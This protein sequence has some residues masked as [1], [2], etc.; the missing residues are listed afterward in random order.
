MSPAS[1]YQAQMTLWRYPDVTPEMIIMAK[2]RGGLTVLAVQNLQARDERY[3]VPDP[4][5]P[6]LFL[7]IHPTGA[8]SWCFRYRFCGK[9]RKLTIGTAY[10]DKGI[11]VVK[12]GDAR[13]IADE[14]RVSVARQIDP[15]A[16]KKEARAKAAK[17]A[18]SA[19]TTLRAVSEAYL[20]AR[21]HL[22]TA[23]HRRKAF[24]RL[25][26]PK[27]GD[28]QIESIR[29]SEIAELMKEIAKTRGVVMADYCLAAMRAVFNS[30]AA[31]SDD[32]T[33]PIRRG[34][35]M[36]STKARAR[37]RTLSRIELAALWRACDRAGIFG[38]YVRFT[39][40]TATRRNEASHLRRTE[41]TGTDWTIPAA[42]Y[43]TKVDH[44]V[45]LSPA[46]VEVLASVPKIGRSG[47]VFTTDGDRPISGFG[48]R[49]EALDKL[50]L[51]E[52]RKLTGDDS[53]ELQRWTLHD[54]R[55]SARSLLSEAKVPADIGER[56]LGHVV[57]GVR[58]IYDRYE[59]LTEKREA[60]I[61]LADLICEIMAK[62]KR[63]IAV[64]A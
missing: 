51:E 56:C 52:L 21:S 38:A 1:V 43:K 23:E 19:E 33:S 55:R 31:T 13:D 39:L 32:Y 46:A 16:V 36:T 45:P 15:G 24:E 48:L 22:R 42:R 57:G 6:G 7:Q 5:C 60:F 61:K 44:V 58:G 25:I 10:T 30:Y 18:A 14:A 28:R 37:S 20:D 59:Y 12:I 54:L 4:G 47:Y 9:P 53:I 26:Y 3:E 2:R 40:L 35:A 27:L 62:K 11:E 63:E 49:K 29:R 64:A 8:K 34:M 50:M 41:I 17:E